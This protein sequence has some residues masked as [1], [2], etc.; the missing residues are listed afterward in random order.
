MTPESLSHFTAL[1]PLKSPE[2]RP[3]TSCRNCFKQGPLAYPVP[4]PDISLSQLPALCYQCA[5]LLDCEV[6]EVTG[7]ITLYLKV[8]PTEA[9]LGSR[10]MPPYFPCLIT[11]WPG[12][13]RFTGSVKKNRTQYNAWFV[14]KGYIWHGISRGNSE[15][16]HCKRTKSQFLQ[17]VLP[18]NH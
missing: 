9:N 16:I 12:T 14:F 2:T 1:P 5:A 17:S 7:R 8:L 13:L 15:L 3:H 10:L 4:Y 18:N 6:M 11:N